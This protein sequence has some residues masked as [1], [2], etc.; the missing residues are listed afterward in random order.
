[1]CGC[2]CRYWFGYRRLEG[3]IYD[4][5]NAVGKIRKSKITFEVVLTIF[6]M[7][8]TWPNLIMSLGVGFSKCHRFL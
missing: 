7:L 6:E 3:Q 2:V 4:I 5:T 1:M 8:I